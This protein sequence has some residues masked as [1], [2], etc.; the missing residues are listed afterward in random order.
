MAFTSPLPLPTTDSR[1]QQNPT[2][3]LKRDRKVG[4]IRHVRLSNKEIRVDE[5]T[6]KN[7]R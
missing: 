7:E 4:C 3:T 2:T 5:Q 1:I 6:K